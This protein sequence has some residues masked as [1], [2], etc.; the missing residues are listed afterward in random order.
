MDG[1]STILGIVLLTTIVIVI[2]HAMNT[3]TDR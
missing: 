2:I 3:S 1:T